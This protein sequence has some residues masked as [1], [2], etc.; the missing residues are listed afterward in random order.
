MNTATNQPEVDVSGGETA[1][2]DW[3]S[4]ELHKL[5]VAETADLKKLIDTEGLELS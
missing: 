2:D 3:T 4:P 5:P 1:L